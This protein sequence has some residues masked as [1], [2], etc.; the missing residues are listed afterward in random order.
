[1]F[2]AAGPLSEFTHI[3]LDCVFTNGTLARWP[4]VQIPSIMGLQAC[5]G[6]QRR[7]AGPLVLGRPCDSQNLSIFSLLPSSQLINSPWPAARYLLSAG[8]SRGTIAPLALFLALL[9][10]ASCSN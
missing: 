8:L 9:A 6:R 1:M 4:A 7:A 3:F 5:W 10:G 2:H